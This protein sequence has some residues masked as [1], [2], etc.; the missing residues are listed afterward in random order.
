[1]DERPGIKP[2]SHGRQQSGMERSK[3]RL[4]DPIDRSVDEQQQ[5]REHRGDPA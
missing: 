5:D 2:V 3:S 4:Q 1:M